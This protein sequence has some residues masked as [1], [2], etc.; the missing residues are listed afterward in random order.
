MSRMGRQRFLHDIL[1]RRTIQTNCPLHDRTHRHTAQPRRERTIFLLPIHAMFYSSE[2]TLGT[3]SS[4]CPSTFISLAPCFVRSCLSACPFY[5][6]QAKS[7]TYDAFTRCCAVRA[8]RVM[9][10]G[11]CVPCSGL[12]V[13]TPD[14]TLSEPHWVS[15]RQ[16]PCVLSSATTRPTHRTTKRRTVYSSIRNISNKQ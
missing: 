8:S 12:F 10:G 2:F 11:R 9:C 7:C 3:E 15:R 16:D 1:Y 13:Q 5:A 14:S 4:R 6:L